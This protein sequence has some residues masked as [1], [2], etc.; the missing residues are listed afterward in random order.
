MKY[1]AIIGSIILGAILVIAVTLGLGYLGFSNQANGFEV[2]IKAKYSNNQNVYDNGFK[3]VMEIAQVPQMQ[4]AGLKELYDGAMKG[5]YGADGSKALLQAIKEQN[6]DLNQTTYIKVQ[7]TIETFR[8]EFQANQT[9][10]I[11]QKQAY[12]RF[13]VATTGGQFYNLIGHY[14]RIDLSAYDIV[15]SDQTQDAFRTKK[16]GPLQLTP[17][18]NK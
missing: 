3:K 2:D 14:P 17:A 18:A 12:E 5:R 1:F 7:E 15:T 13:L 6:P 10:L 4:V 9:G 11:S 8:N 16:A